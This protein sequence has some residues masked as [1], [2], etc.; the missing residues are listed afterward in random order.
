[1]LP[2]PQASSPS[3]SSSRGPKPPSFFR[4]KPHPIHHPHYPRQPP[5][6]PEPP[7]AS[8]ALGSSSLPRP[9][10]HA[11]PTINSNNRDGRPRRSCWVLLIGDFIARLP[12]RLIAFSYCA[13]LH[14]IAATHTGYRV[15]VSSVPPASIIRL[16]LRLLPDV[17]DVED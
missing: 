13:W 10:G 12:R 15:K 17:I 3:Y 16:A 7:S 1:M 14:F 9:A 11:K 5:E 4:E 2:R 6:D 8:K